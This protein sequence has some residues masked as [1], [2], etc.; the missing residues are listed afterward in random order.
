M[1][2]SRE[3]LAWASG[4]ISGEGGF[5]VGFDKIQNLHKILMS[6]GQSGRTCPE[7]LLRL[8]S[9]LGIGRVLPRKSSGLKKTINGV[10]P[11]WHFIATSFKDVQAIGA[12][13]WEWLTPEKCAQFIH[14]LSVYRAE[15][16]Y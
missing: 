9:I 11:Q 1:V 2:R 14:A 5:Y 6:V 10:L 7:M 4:V 13:T 8:Q 12:M 15:R 16:R 3:Q